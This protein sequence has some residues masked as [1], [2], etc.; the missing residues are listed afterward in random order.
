MPWEL[1]DFLDH[2]LVRSGL[3][4]LQPIMT[5]EK[6]LSPEAITSFQRVASLESCLYMR[7]QLLRD[8][9][10]ASM[11]HSL[12]I[13]V[14]LV[15]ATLLSNLAPIMSGDNHTQIKKVFGQTPIPPIPELALN[16]KKTGFKTPIEKWMKKINF[17]NEALGQRVGRSQPWAREWARKVMDY[18]ISGDF[19]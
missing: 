9:D 2:E 16:R 17:E 13:R 10:W 4:A 8:S 14:P 3:S 11:A 12:E 1:P 5:I 18:Q 7:N 15:D 6:E 19:S